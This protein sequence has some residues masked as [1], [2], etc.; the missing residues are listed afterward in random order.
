M[1]YMIFFTFGLAMIVL[2]FFVST[3]VST[4]SVAYSVRYL[5]NLITLVI[6][7]IFI[8]IADHCI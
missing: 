4:Q 8:H 1:L 5:N 3:L 2:A 6:D 7:F